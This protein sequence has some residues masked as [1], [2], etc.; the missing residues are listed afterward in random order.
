[1]G[2]ALCVAKESIKP[3]RRPE[4]SQPL[5]L[6]CVSVSSWPIPVADEFFSGIARRHVILT[7][8]ARALCQATSLC[9]GSRRKLNHLAAVSWLNEAASGFVCLAHSDD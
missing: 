5:F 9:C 3:W 7:H 2:P 8:N 4:A 1:M 6:P